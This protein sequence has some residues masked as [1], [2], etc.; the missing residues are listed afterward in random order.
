MKKLKLFGLVLPALV[1]GS[2]F[3]AENVMSLS[4]DGFFDRIEKLDKPEFQNVKL[5]FYL[6]E[7]STGK[8]CGIKSVELKTKLKSKKVYFYESG[9][10][11]LPFDNSFVS[12]LL[13]RKDNFLVLEDGPISQKKTSIQ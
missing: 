2:V 10:V 12:S 9:E 8:P 3:A 7:M 1:C 6:T 11:V 13:L 4:Y 5:A